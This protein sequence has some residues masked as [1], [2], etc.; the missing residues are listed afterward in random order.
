[1]SK[2][3][4]DTYKQISEELLKRKMFVSG[5]DFGTVFMVQSTVSPVGLR[6][7]LRRL[8]F[9]AHV[10]NGKLWVCEKGFEEDLEICMEEEEAIFQSP[11]FA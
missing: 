7:R 6:W 2:I 9:V 8:G 11:A 5:A 10:V 1:M 3:I 4:R